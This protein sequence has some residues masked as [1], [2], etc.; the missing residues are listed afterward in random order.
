MKLVKS[1]NDGEQSTTVNCSSCSRIVERK[2]K[3]F[4]TLNEYNDFLKT[5]DEIKFCEM[6]KRKLEAKVSFDDDSLIKQALAFTGVYSAFSIGLSYATN[7]LTEFAPFFVIPA[8]A[9]GLAST[10]SLE[11]CKNK[12]YSNQVEKY[13]QKQN[14]LKKKQKEF[15]LSKLEESFYKLL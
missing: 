15:Y 7:L 9:L 2:T 3:G 13:E 4:L 8:F 5:N 10:V 14:D 6:K 1:N 11:S 12:Y